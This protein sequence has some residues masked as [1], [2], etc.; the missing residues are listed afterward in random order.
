MPGYQ[1]DI[2]NKSYVHK[3]NL[4]RHVREKHNNLEFWNCT[5]SGCMTKFIRREYLSK[6]LRVQH[7]YAKFKAHEA[8]CLAPRG[9]VQ[10]DTYYDYESEDDTVFD[11]IAEMGEAQYNSTCADTID[12][13]DNSMFDEQFDYCDDVELGDEEKISEETHSNDGGVSSEDKSKLNDEVCENNGEN[14]DHILD[15]INGD[16][17][18]ENSDVNF[19]KEMSSEK[20]EVNCENSDMILDG[21]NANLCDDKVDQGANRYVNIFSDISSDENSDELDGYAEISDDDIGDDHQISDSD[22]YDVV[23]I[24]SDDECTTIAIPDEIVVEET[25]VMALTRRKRVINGGVTATEF[26]LTT[27]YYHN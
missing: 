19:N 12:N 27:D 14:S 25:F 1:C 26:T 16:E 18:D 2:C 3:R 7:G 21:I 9:D 24:C 10:H 13:F 6:H 11:M 20:C 8:A 4:K 5:E 17:C 22:G 23:Y 15:W